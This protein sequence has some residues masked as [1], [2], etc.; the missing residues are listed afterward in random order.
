MVGGPHGGRARKKAKSKGENLGTKIPF[1]IFVLFFVRFLFTDTAF[2]SPENDPELVAAGV[3]DRVMFG[4]DLPLQAG[5]YEGTIDELNVNDLEGARKYGYSE[6]VMS[7][8]F[9]RFLAGN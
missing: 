5:F 3:E 6:K 9:H 1:G 4:T 2:M 8:N 7:G